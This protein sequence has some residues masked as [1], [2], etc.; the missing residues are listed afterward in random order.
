MD[1]Q[2]K[3]NVVIQIPEEYILIEKTEYE[4]LKIEDDLGKWWTLSDVMNRV[5]RRRTWLLDNL[6][7]NPKYRNR[8]D[9]RKGGFVKYPTGGKDSYLFL[10]SETKKFL[11]D[12]FQ[13]LLK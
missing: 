10:A 12:N 4:R 11:E 5:N 6:L 13:E 8:I 7:N 9:I 2:I 1:Q 3:A